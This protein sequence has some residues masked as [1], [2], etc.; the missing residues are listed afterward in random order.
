MCLHFVDDLAYVISFF[1]ILQFNTFACFNEIHTKT[2]TR[3]VY[4]RVRKIDNHRWYLIEIGTVHTLFSKGWK[5]YFSSWLLFFAADSRLVENT[6][7]LKNSWY[8]KTVTLA[9]CC[10]YI[11]THIREWVRDKYKTR[12]FKNGQCS[13]AKSIFFLNAYECICIFFAESWM[14]RT[15]E[16]W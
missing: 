7:H 8:Q 9:R 2:H 5:L 1:S 14:Q 3:L 12:I 10:L 4:N 11:S 13:Y 6:N 16:T 15:I